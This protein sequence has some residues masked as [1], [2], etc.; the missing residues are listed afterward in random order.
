[1]TQAQ[2][3]TLQSENQHLKALLQKPQPHSPKVCLSNIQLRFFCVGLGMLL[4][5]DLPLHPLGNGILTNIPAAALHA[6]A[7]QPGKGKPTLTAA[8]L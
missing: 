3:E 4:I 7:E 8:A 1:M 2:L 6:P 5:P